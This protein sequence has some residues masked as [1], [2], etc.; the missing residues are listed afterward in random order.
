MRGKSIITIIRINCASSTPKHCA[1]VVCL[2]SPG[3]IV[4]AL[5]FVLRLRVELYGFFQL[6]NYFG[7]IT[8]CSVKHAFEL[9][10]YLC[11]GFHADFPALRVI[12]KGPPSLRKGVNRLAQKL[13]QLLTHILDCEC[14]GCN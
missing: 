2:I 5:C 1:H 10:L 3:P 12:D 7:L 9:G 8:E 11:D 6:R 13:I 14:L 4:W